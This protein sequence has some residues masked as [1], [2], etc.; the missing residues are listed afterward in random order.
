[1]LQV[2]RASEAV[3]SLDRTVDESRRQKNPVGMGRSLL[4]AS[5]AY[6]LSGDVAR[7]TTLTEEAAASIN[8]TL[9]P[10]H[11]GR[12]A[13]L[14]Q[15]GRIALAHGD[16]QKARD[17]L[18]ESIAMFEMAGPRSSDRALTLAVLADVHRLRGE[19]SEALKRAEEAL[20]LARKSA[21]DLPFSYRVGVAALAMCEAG[22]AA[23]RADSAQLCDLAIAQLA[24]A[25]GEEAPVTQQARALLTRSEP[26]RYR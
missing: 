5:R 13:L 15:Q 11:V 26:G 23:S 9:P 24:G 20:A 3:A 8:A 18:L 10:R 12:A 21:G 17:L 6:L 25:A 2:G 19:Y 4:V 16:T 22:I 14:T 7:A 1:L